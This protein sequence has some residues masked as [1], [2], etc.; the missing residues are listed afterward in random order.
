MELLASPQGKKSQY[1]ELVREVA[2]ELE[3]IYNNKRAYTV[4][5]NVSGCHKNDLLVH[6]SD[7][8]LRL[9]KTDN[10]EVE[11]L[12]SFILPADVDTKAI[13]AVF[14][15]H[16][17]KIVLRRNGQRKSQYF[18]LNGLLKTLF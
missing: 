14:L 17:L 8:M 13:K 5:L 10:R 3:D 4:L 1:P 16:K 9:E 18:S 7:G 15:Q 11:L 6:V 12:F 2:A